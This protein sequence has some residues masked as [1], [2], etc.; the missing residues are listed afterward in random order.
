MVSLKLK[1]EKKLVAQELE[2]KR[3]HHLVL[4]H[5]SLN[6]VGECLD[7]VSDG[8][9]KVHDPKFIEAEDEIAIQVRQE[10]YEAKMRLIQ[11]EKDHKDKLLKD[12]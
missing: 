7:L 1:I 2:A 6:V 12:K 5:G 4:K 8:A 11:Q 10:K 9:I 3:K